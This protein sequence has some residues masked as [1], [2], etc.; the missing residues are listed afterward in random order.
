MNRPV[1]LTFVDAVG[2]PDCRGVERAELREAGIDGAEREAAPT[3]PGQ[4][5]GAGPAGPLPAGQLGPPQ[6]DLL[7]Q[8]RQQR[9]LLVRTED[10]KTTA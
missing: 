3:S 1:G 10:L 5:D 6:A 7:T 4:G 9:R 8:E 2:R